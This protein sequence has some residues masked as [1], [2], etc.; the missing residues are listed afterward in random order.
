MSNLMNTYNRFNLTLTKGEGVYV[1]D[2]KG[3]KYLDFVSGIATNSLG[4]SNDTYKKALKNQID[5]LMH[6]SNLYSTEINEEAAKILSELSGFETVFF[7]NSGTEAVEAALKLARIQSKDK[8]E[9]ISMKNSFHGR[10]MG[11][12]TLTGQEKY[13]S[14]FTPLVPGVSYATFNDFDSFTELVTDKT[15]AVIIELIQGEGGINVAD[16]TYIKKLNDYC[17]ENDIFIIIDE[18]QTGVARTATFYTYMQYEIEPDIIATAKGLGAGFPVGAILANKNISEKFTYGK[19]GTTFGGNPLASRAVYEVCNQ[20]KE[21]DIQNNVKNVSN[22]LFKELEELKETIKGMK[23]IRGLGLLIGIEFDSEI[24]VKTIVQ[25]SIDKGLLLVTAG[26]N[27]IRLVPPL[28]VTNKEI[29]EAIN[30]IKNV[31]KEV[32]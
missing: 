3:N 8:Y 6:C 28:V 13:Q 17:K 10:T 15:C 24:D 9:I 21:L 1:Y 2:T 25:K 32:I 11:S 4:Y 12:I 22:Y 20:M 16:Q 23:E 30:I 5:S 29:D 18:V 27:T 31:L 19:H 26:A 14:D 7:V